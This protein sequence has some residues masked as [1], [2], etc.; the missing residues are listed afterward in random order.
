MLIWLG[1]LY[2]GPQWWPLLAP[3]ELF[4]SRFDEAIP[5]IPGTAWIYQSLFVLLP[6]AA[7]AQSSSQEFLKFTVGFCG[8]VL[9][10]STVF[11]LYPTELRLS[12]PSQ[13]N[14]GY[15]HLIAA[16]DGRRNAFPS[17]HAA[18]TTYAG[19]AIIRSGR[20][21]KL[22]TLSVV[23]W[24]IALLLSTLTTK[25]HICLDVIVGTL[26]GSL[27]SMFL[28]YRIP[29]RPEALLSF[30]R[31]EQKV[32]LVDKVKYRCDDGRSKSK[33]AL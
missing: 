22:L 3:Q 17:L 23:I 30:D 7:L 32:D 14:W 21:G 9:C 31:L 15:G 10:V 19:I 29:G 18:L 5:F 27:A 11:W 28:Y 1:L 26:S 25:Q 33:Q 24:M 20:Q 13:S 12:L 8:L 6:I 2:Y 4:P 16:I